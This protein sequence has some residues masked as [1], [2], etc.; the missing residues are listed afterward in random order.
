ME[1]NSITI[2]GVEGTIVYGWHIAATVRDWT[3][4]R[5][6]NAPGTVTATVVTHNAQWVSQRPLV[7]VP[8]KDKPWRWQIESLQ[9]VDDRITASLSPPE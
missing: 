5:A 2:R 4:V 1:S 9:F 3:A 8:H 7:F 6:G